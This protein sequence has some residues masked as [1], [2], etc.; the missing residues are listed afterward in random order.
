MPALSAV[1]LIFSFQFSPLFFNISLARPH[2]H[3]GI[4]LVLITQYRT[5]DTAE[6][7]GRYLSCMER[8]AQRND[9]ELILKVK[10]E[11]RHHVEGPFG[12][13]FPALCNHCGV[14][15]SVLYM[16]LHMLNNSCMPFLPRAFNNSAGVL[17]VLSVLLV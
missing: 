3:S 14:H 15:S 17:S 5:L 4:L 12:C 1:L 2:Q 9:F 6:N 7:L 16:S 10:T 11:T 8:T 13:E